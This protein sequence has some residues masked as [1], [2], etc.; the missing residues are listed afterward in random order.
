MDTKASAI[1][2][3]SVREVH[4]ISQW[5][6]WFDTRHVCSP[7][8]VCYPI[9]CAACVRLFVFQVISLVNQNGPRI[10]F[11]QLWAGILALDRVGTAADDG[12]Q[13]AM[14]PVLQPC[15]CSRCHFDLVAVVDLTD[16]NLDD[17]EG[18]KEHP[19]FNTIVSNYNMII[20]VCGL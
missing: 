16:T 18:I 7:C 5:R 20:I 2:F 13:R 3:H 1:L 4:P 17:H 12:G 9:A 6:K 8:I 14:A 10:N 19:S 11:L 15:R